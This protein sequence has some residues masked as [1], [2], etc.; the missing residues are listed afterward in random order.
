MKSVISG[1]EV[2]CFMELGINQALMKVQKVYF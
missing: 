1:S 2:L